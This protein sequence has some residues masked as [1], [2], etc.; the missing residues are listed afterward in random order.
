M[1]TPADVPPRS[2]QAPDDPFNF[3]F[4]VLHLVAPLA[5]LA[6]A[7]V[8]VGR[9]LGPSVAG[10]G[11]GMDR[12][13]PAIE[14][15]G[16]LLSQLCGMFAI[17][18]CLAELLTL[19]RSRVAP[20]LRVASLVLGGAVI[21]GGFFASSRTEGLPLSTRAILG[22]SASLLAL[23]TATRALKAPFARA[24][25]LVV[26]LVGLG[27]LLRLGAVALAYQAVE[28]GWSRLVP[29]ARGLA[30]AGFAAGG[31]GLAVATAWIA[32][33]SKRLT[34]PVTLGLLL[35]ALIITRQALIAEHD[36]AGVGSLLLRRALGRLVPRPEPFVPAAVQ[37]F[38]AALSPLVA[39]AA[40]F[41]RTV[42]LR[43]GADP[44]APQARL[45]SA[46]GAS[47]ALALLVGDAPEMPLGALFLV[48]AGLSAALAAEDDRGVWAGIVQG[49]PSGTG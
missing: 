33:R 36:D 2:P 27:S 11:V 44:S 42:P 18:L 25:A 7:A 38:V 26:A 45:P 49:K 43:E 32:S 39:V 13:I 5:G 30:T 6:I 22:V 40:L 9:A 41:S 17:V 29:V 3:G 16:G 46:L 47:I 8:I 34:N 19:H 12:I 4:P 24:T 23:L 20:L 10:V 21:L 48:I 1:S 14:Y 35:V 31:L 37:I 28:P 15:V